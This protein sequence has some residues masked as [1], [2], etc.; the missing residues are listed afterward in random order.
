MTD[1]PETLK[2]ALAN[3]TARVAAFEKARV[4]EEEPEKVAPANIDCLLNGTAVPYTQAIAGRRLRYCERELARLREG[5]KVQV[6]D[7]CDENVAY[8]ANDPRHRTDREYGVIRAHSFAREIQRHR[9][10]VGGGK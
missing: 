5:L 8:W 7:E 1:T 3:L 9:A 6:D 2:A 4:E 10:L